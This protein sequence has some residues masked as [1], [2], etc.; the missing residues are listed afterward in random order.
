MNKSAIR[1]RWRS[2]RVYEFLGIR[3]E[4]ASG[5]KARLRLPW[6]E[7]LTQPLGYT[8]GGIIATLADA[9]AG[10]ALFPEVDDAT[11]CTTL[12]MQVNFLA[13]VVKQDMVATARV[14]RLGRTTAL[15][16]VDVRAGRKLCAKAL[17]TYHIKR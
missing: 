11:G 6:R 10:W 1:A 2:I 4:S 15:M 5:G 12:Q 16:D 7:E 14:V 17:V 9:A 3:V 13:P 8:H